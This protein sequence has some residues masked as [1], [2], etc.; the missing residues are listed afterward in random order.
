MTDE[1]TTPPADEKPA[2]PAAEKPAAKKPA[3]KKP[4][5]S[6]GGVTVHVLLD[7]THGDH[8]HYLSGRD[9]EVGKATAAWLLDD[10]RVAVPV[11][12][13]GKTETATEE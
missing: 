3:A 9:Y 12:R 11:K 4:A 10:P 13:T 2:D 1:T 5:S 8:G 6:S 7:A